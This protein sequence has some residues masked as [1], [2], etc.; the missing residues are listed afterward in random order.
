[1][2]ACKG[3]FF[4]FVTFEKLTSQAGQPGQHLHTPYGRRN[5]GT[6]R[7]QPGSIV[8]FTASVYPGRV[9]GDLARESGVLLQIVRRL[10]RVHTR[11]RHQVQTR[12]KR[13]TL[14]DAQ[15]AR[16]PTRH[17]VTLGVG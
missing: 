14:R 6:L 5:A 8:S 3:I 2:K 16:V 4:V 9:E 7:V 12:M 10:Q 1:M 17:N 11:R 15:R 13:G